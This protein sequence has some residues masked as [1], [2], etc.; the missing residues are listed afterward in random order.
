MSSFAFL[1]LV[2]RRLQQFTLWRLEAARRGAGRI[3]AFLRLA[4]LRRC[5]NSA[6]SSGTRRLDGVNRCPSLCQPLACQWRPGDLCQAAWSEDGVVYGATIKSVDASAGTCVVVFTGYGNEDE[7][8]LADLLPPAAESAAGAGGESDAA[9]SCDADAASQA[10]KESAPSADDYEMPGRP[11]GG[12]GAR[13]KGHKQKQSVPPW[14]YPSPPLSHPPPFPGFPPYPNAWGGFPPPPPHLSAAALP[15]IPPP[16]LPPSAA[17]PD[18]DDEALGSMLLAWYMSG[19]H[20]GYY[21]GLKQGKKDTMAGR[22]PRY[23]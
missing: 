17:F 5:A 8:K 14:A 22:G 23:K 15:M 18:D 4:I 9:A 1:P 20:T 12:H 10:G 3:A 16:P 21:Q 7:L 11:K 6:C 13:K 19:Y 2:E